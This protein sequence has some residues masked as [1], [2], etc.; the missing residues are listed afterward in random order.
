M[1]RFS[2]FTTIPALTNAGGA[3]ADPCVFGGMDVREALSAG[4][5]VL[6]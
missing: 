3:D 1:Y 6:S 4:G 5:N 2:V